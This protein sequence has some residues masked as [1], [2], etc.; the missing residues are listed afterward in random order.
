MSPKSLT[1]IMVSVLT[2]IALIMIGASFFN[3]LACE[4]Q[5]V[6]TTVAT[7]AQQIWG[8]RIISQS[9]I[10]PRHDLNRIDLL[11]QTYDRRNTHLVNLRLLAMTKELNNPLQGAELFNTTFNADTIS[12]QSWHSFTFSPLPDSAGKTYLITL[13]SPESE[14][15]NAITV[16]G[17]A[18]DTYL[19]GT[20]YLG[21]TPVP[22][23]ITFRSCYQMTLLEKLQVLSAQTTR[24]RSGWWA[25]NIFYLLIF[26]LYSLLFI[27]LSY[28]LIALSLK[29]E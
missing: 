18:R 27:G 15:G 17:A 5:P 19:T 1:I 20:A 9:F 11:F 25:N 23:D 26:M 13:T 22:F 16:G 14:D 6:H 29:K 7:T 10:A 8:E 3:Q 24:N 12:D 4:G 28:K 21:A 2:L